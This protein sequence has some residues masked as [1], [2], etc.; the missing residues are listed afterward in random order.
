MG[1]KA[2]GVDSVGFL[3]DGVFVETGVVEEKKS[4]LGNRWLKESLYEKGSWERWGSKTMHYC[5]I[6]P[7]AQ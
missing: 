3:D 1:E 5:L 7:P 4:G 2:L 6:Q